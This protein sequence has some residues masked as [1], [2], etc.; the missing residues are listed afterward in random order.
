[1]SVEIKRGY[2]TSNKSLIQWK[3]KRDTRR[4]RN[5]NTQSCFLCTSFLSLGGVH[6]MLFQLILVK[7]LIPPEVAH[8]TYSAK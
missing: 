5:S 8:K 3:I 1:M 4:T 2:F 6:A 7:Q